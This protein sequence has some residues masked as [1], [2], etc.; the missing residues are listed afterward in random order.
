MTL[1]LSIC[2]KNLSPSPSP[3]DAPSINPGRSATTKLLL[4]LVFTTPKLGFNVVKWYAAILGFERDI[5]ERIVLLPTLGIPTKPTSASNLSSTFKYLSSPG[6]PFSLKLG[7]GLFAVLKAV[8]P[9]PPRP[10]LAT[11]H[12]SPSSFKS[13]ITRFVSI[14]VTTVPVGTFIIIS[15]APLPLQFLPIPFSPRSPLIILLYLKSIKVR[16]PSSALKIIFDPLPPFP[17]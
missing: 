4:S 16:S 14:S 15:L 10:P 12:S 3:K 2:F 1:V 7:A 11:I 17:P 13:Q 9:R 8:F 5:L 6:S